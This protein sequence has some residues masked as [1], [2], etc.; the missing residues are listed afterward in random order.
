MIEDSLEAQDLFPH[1][2]NQCEWNPVPSNFSFY[3]I[4]FNQ[5]CF[6]PRDYCHYFSSYF[7]SYFSH[8]LKFRPSFQIYHKFLS[9][10]F[11][12]SLDLVAEKI[13]RKMLAAEKFWFHTNF[14]MFFIFFTLRH[15]FGKYW[16]D[17]P[18]RYLRLSV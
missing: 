17:V 1:P 15:Y 2:F 3:H 18:K 9:K 7:S 12:Y 4:C 13:G 5:L 11:L 10:D 14:G 8:K 16:S 6:L